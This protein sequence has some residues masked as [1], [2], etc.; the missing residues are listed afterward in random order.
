MANHLRQ[1]VLACARIGVAAL[2]VPAFVA[3]GPAISSAQEAFAAPVRAQAPDP[4]M[5]A[6]PTYV[7]MH[8]TRARRGGRRPRP[9]RVRSVLRAARSAIGTPYRYGGSSKESGFDCSGLTMWAWRRGGDSLPH[10]SSQQYQQVRH[11][12]RANLQPGDLVFFYSPIHHVGLYVGDG[13]M[14]AAPHSGERVR[15]QRVYWQYF[16]GAGRPA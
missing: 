9:E 8:A 4:T 2:L 11:V 1:L 3:G 13:W 10:S 5:H 14:I 16:T 15:R 12:R 6:H 7:R